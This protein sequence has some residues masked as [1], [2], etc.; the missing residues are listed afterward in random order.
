VQ[1]RKAWRERGT[2]CLSEAT[3]TVA[4]SFI[5]DSGHNCVYPSVTVS[6]DIMVAVT[7]PDHP[8]MDTTGR[9]GWREWR[10]REGGRGRWRG[11]EG[12]EEGKEGSNFMCSVLKQI[13]TRHACDLFQALQ[14]RQLQGTCLIHEA[15]KR[16]TLVEDK[17]DP[18]EPTYM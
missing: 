3:F 6:M 15:R 10:G 11:K 14:V 17:A 2:E 1:E 5:D 7:I 9:G 18:I 13:Q 12:R 4:C 8:W 16:N